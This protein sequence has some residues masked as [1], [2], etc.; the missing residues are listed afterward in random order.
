MPEEDRIKLLKKGDSVTTNQF[1]NEGSG[2]QS[3]KV[4][5]WKTN[6]NYAF[7][8]GAKPSRKGYTD[9]VAYFFDPEMNK[10]NLIAEFRRPRT[11]TH[12]KGLYSFLENFRPDQGATPRRG[13]YQNQ[14][15]FNS[16]GWH[17]ITRAVFTADNT[18]RKGYRLDYSG[19]NEGSGFYLKNCGLTNDHTTIGTLLERKKLNKP[20]KI[21][22]NSLD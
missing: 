11:T 6:I 14:W 7:L 5:D 2:G 4:F 18:A 17:E 12:L 8:V 19:G 16:F 13:L 3:F 21:D 1:G 10:W 20:P 22:F 9:Y 15:A